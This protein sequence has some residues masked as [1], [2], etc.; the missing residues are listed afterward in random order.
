MIWKNTLTLS[1]LLLLTITSAQDTT[2]IELN[3]SIPPLYDSV[4]VQEDC[5]NI[6]IQQRS[7]NNELKRQ[8]EYIRNILNENDPE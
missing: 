5:H 4:K 2:R 6:M 3:D 7:I 1:T 8:L